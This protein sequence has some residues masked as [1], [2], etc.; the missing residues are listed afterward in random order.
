MLFN[1]YVAKHHRY[2]LAMGNYGLKLCGKMYNIRVNINENAG[3]LV[4]I[5]N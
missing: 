5:H 3:H 1:G 2:L 4:I